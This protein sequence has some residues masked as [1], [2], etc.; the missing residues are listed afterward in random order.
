[1]PIEIQ[2]REPPVL[3]LW[4]QALAQLAVAR[5]ARQLAQRSVALWVPLL[6]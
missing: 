1:M 4:A 6:V 5:R 3:T 2:S